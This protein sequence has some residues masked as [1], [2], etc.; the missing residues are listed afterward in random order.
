[1]R[2]DSKE[3][4]MHKGVFQRKNSSDLIDSNKENSMR[5]FGKDLTNNFIVKNGRKEYFVGSKGNNGANSQTMNCPPKLSTQITANSDNSF[6]M[7]K[8][9]NIVQFEDYREMIIKYLNE[10]DISNTAYN[11]YLQIQNDIS[12]KIRTVIIDWMID[13]ATQFNLLNETLFLSVMILDKYLEKVIVK[14]T[15]VQL[16]GITTLFIASKYQEIYPPELID[17]QSRTNNAYSCGEIIQMEGKILVAL[18]FN[19]GFVTTHYILKLLE[20]MIKFK[21]EEL[22]LAQYFLFLGLSSYKMRFYQS[23]TQAI[24]AVYAAVKIISKDKEI[25]NKLNSI[26]GIEEMEIKKCSWDLIKL[27]QSVNSLG[28]PY[29]IQKFSEEKYNKI[30]SM[31]IG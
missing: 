24:S 5:Q 22:N 21:S 1:M 2:I 10:L 15:E 18:G 16:I 31:K 12:E 6:K 3:K 25:F 19:I 28:I 26:M 30:A 17:F 27:F 9:D 8:R 11:N 20:N 7:I 29:T 14:K 23:I 13:V 4:L